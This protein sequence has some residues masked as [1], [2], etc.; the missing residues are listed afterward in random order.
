MYNKKIIPFICA[1]M[2]VFA[3]CKKYDEYIKDYDFSA[4]YF[5]SQKPLRTIVAYDE[6]SFKV[7]VTL[8]GKRENTKEEW[9]TYEIDPSLLD[10]TSFTLLPEP[11]Y[12]ISDNEKIVVPK[13]RFIGDVTVKLNREAFTADPL[14]T[15]NT[16]ALPLRLK[17]TSADSI[18]QG[19]IDEEGSVLVAPKDYTILVVKYISPFHGTYYHKGVEQR[20][21]NTGNVVETKKYSVK[22]LSKNQ[23]WDIS[24][25]SSNEVLTS[26]AGTFSSQTNNPYRLNLVINAD[27][28]VA[29]APVTGSKAIVQSGNG[30]YNE[31]KREF[32][33][34]YEFSVNSVNYKAVDTLVLRQ[35]PELD[36]R[37]EEW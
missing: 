11:Y 14:S 19:S 30:T 15:V 6:M 32:Y 27:N 13:G 7:G 26:G 8:A 34:N 25:V 36:L 31:A 2:L 1:A 16:Y 3:S 23:T 10:N 17:E 9:V 35:A 28:T 29:I 12:S 4:V 21:D 37:F 24:T 22:D 20:L 5:G 33:L 18:L